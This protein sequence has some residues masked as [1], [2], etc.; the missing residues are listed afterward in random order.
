MSDASRAAP[1]GTNGEI[2]GVPPFRLSHEYVV[3]STSRD[4]SIKISTPDTELYSYLAA[5]DSVDIRRRWLMDRYG[6]YE[7]TRYEFDFT[8]S[9]MVV[10]PIKRNY[11]K[12]TTTRSGGGVRR[13][14][15]TDKLFSQ[16]Y[17]DMISLR[18]YRPSMFEKW[19][20]N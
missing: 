5:G 12:S 19:S 3:N 13:Y 18:E 16:M 9:T 7:K 1:H 4:F 11:F 20:E 10:L 8:D 2:I 15:L 14:V 17:F 6:F